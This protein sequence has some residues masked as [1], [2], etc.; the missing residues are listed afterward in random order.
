MCWREEEQD[1]KPT[2]I[3]VT[4]GAGGVRVSNRVG[5]LGEFR[6]STQLYRDGARRWHRVRVYY[7]EVAVL[8]TEQ[9]AALRDQ[10]RQLGRQCWRRL[11]ARTTWLALV[12]VTLVTGL[13]IAL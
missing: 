12:L 6:G 4:L 7:D 13:V 10:L 9:R 1:G 2:K 3:P 11:A 5:N 8:E